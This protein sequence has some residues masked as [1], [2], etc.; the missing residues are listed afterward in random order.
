MKALIKGTPTLSQIKAAGVGYHVR[1]I[2][3]DHGGDTPTVIYDV[4]YFDGETCRYSDDVYD[5]EAEARLAASALDLPDV[6]P[7]LWWDEYT[8]MAEAQ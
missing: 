1:G 3:E 2:E 8:P 6:P 7:P 4:I 5:T